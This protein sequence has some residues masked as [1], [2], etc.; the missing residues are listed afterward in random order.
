MQ[1]GLHAVGDHASPIPIERRRRGAREADGKEQPDAIGST[2]VEIVA[3]DRFE[4]LATLQRPIEDLRETQLELTDGE[5]MVVSRRTLQGSHRP[6]QPAGPSAEE[7][8]DL[9]GTEGIARGL[10]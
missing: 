6:W 4:E 9:V 3:N 1:T 2:Q 10:E 8:L 7:G 5:S